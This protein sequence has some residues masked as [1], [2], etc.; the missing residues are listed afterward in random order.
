MKPEEALRRVIEQFPWKGYVN[1]ARG[2]HL[3]V[4]RTAL[5]F[6]EPG[7]R[8]LDFGSG[9]CDKT[10]VLQLL[11]F[12]CSAWDDLQD[13]WHRLG[14]N[15]DKIVAFARECGIDFTLA[16][17]NAFPY[18]QG[19]FDMVMLHDVLEHLH[20][21]PRELLNDLLEL[22]KPEGYLFATVPN[23][24]NVRKRL[25]VL[26]GKTNLPRFDGY[27]WYPGPWRGHVREYTGDDLNKLSAYLDLEVLQLSTCD[28]MLMNLPKVARPFYRAITRVFTGWKDSWLLVAKKK[29][30]WSPRRNLPEKELAEV[31]GA[32]TR[33]QY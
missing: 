32:A 10:A 9:P 24:V 8:I 19:S 11:G 7:A 22:V 26:F 30:N 33:Y 15:V 4:A 23:A 25:A 16:A 21:S 31:L 14:D 2:A 28:H 12:E 1:P 17:D 18:Q 29:P 27:Y 3:N 5:R 20:D 6:L 13:Y